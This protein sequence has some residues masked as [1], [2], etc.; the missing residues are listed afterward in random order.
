MVWVVTFG[1]WNVGESPADVRRAELVA[2]VNQTIRGDYKI[3]MLSMKGGVGKTT[4]TVGLGSTFAS[5]R[6][7]HV[8]AADANPDRAPWVL[9]YRRKPWRRCG[10]CSTT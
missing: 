5:L 8:V 9:G 2:R 6:G 1:L 7:D 10:I 4:T 3:A